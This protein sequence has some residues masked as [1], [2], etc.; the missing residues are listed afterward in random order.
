MKK[1]AALIIDLKKS[2]SYK[3]LDRIEI[4]NFIKYVIESLNEIFC[5]SIAFNVI[6]SAGDEVQG[7]FDSPEA[8]YLFFRLFSMLISPVE[9]RAGI[10]VGDWDIKIDSA[11]SNEQDGPAYHNARYAIDNVEDSL[12]YSVLLYSKNEN[13]IYINSL[14]NTATLLVNNQSEYQNAL[15]MLTELIFPIELN[16][17]INIDK[18]KNIRHLIARKNNMRYYSNWKSSRSIKA[19]PLILT[20]KLELECNPINAI[21]D[22][23]FFYVSSGK[24]KGLSVKLAKIL[25]T[26]RQSIEK[27]IKSGNIFQARNYTIAA[28]KL[29]NKYV[30][31]DEI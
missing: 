21:Q 22:E 28:L 17:T 14:I 6:F 27:S 15:F 8:A 31:G 18:L 20:E 29:M 1:Y 2:R 19:Y 25:G 11:N 4:Q 7:L 30:T 5:K 23:T 26:S 3:Q 10:G 9:I 16:S 13:D 24:I 12:G